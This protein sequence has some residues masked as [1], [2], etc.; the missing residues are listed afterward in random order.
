MLQLFSIANTILSNQI[1]LSE[2]FSF[3]RIFLDNDK[4]FWETYDHICNKTNRVQLSQ[5][6]SEPS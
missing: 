1:L 4:P 5:A 6:N 3:L 2:A